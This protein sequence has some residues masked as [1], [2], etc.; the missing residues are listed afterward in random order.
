MGLAAWDDAG[1]KYEGMPTGEA[2]TWRRL[3]RLDS[4]CSQLAWVGGGALVDIEVREC[5]VPRS[6]RAAV[7]AVAALSDTPAA[8]G[9]TVALPAAATP[10]VGGLQVWPLQAEYF[11]A[12]VA[13]AMIVVAATT[14]YITRWLSTEVTSILAIAA[15]ALTNV[16]TPAEAFAGFSSTD[17]PTVRALLVLSARLLRTGAL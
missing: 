15:L 11:P 6:A 3:H 2:A 9:A 5:H 12:L 13:G 1:W 16:L 4:V 10:P 17:T 7:R 8:G 14:L